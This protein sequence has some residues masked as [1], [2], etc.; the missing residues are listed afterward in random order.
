[1]KACNSS[2]VSVMNPPAGQLHDPTKILGNVDEEKRR[3]SNPHDTPDKNAG[4][5]ISD[6]LRETVIKDQKREARN[7]DAE[8][9]NANQPSQR[10]SEFC[11]AIHFLFGIFRR[12]RAEG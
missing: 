10:K 4:R 8:E 5:H 1:M 3:A 2:L 7:P 6:I 11:L 9:A 12:C